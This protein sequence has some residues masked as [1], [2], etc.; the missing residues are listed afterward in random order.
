MAKK[1]KKNKVIRGKKM[2]FPHNAER[3][4]LR[5]LRLVLK[6]IRDNTV[7]LLIQRL[8]I[9]LTSAKQDYSN[10]S[11]SDALDRIIEEIDFLADP[12][13]VKANIGIRASGL[14]IAKYNS[15]QIRKTYDQGLGVN[16]F[17]QEP[18]LSTQLES[19]NEQGSALILSLSDDE[20]SSVKQVVL[21]S[22][23]EGQSLTNTIKNIQ[24]R[25]AISY[26]HAKLIARDQT[27]K[28]NGSLT[29]LR[30]ENLGVETYIWQTSSDDRVRASHKVL[31]GMEC[32]WIDSSVYRIPGEDKW[33]KKSSINAFEG[34]IGQDFQCRCV[35]IPVL[36]EE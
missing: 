25:F 6:N 13:R 28:L 1:K 36:N 33:R 10:R 21:R 35:S 32:S 14:E 16:I 7:Q 20:I 30:Q 23:S 34:Q 29:R 26:R 5:S 8:P 11:W 3:L 24:K 18:W 12:E 4:Y 2:I 27:A 22:V 15:K 19:F 31:D 17:S 9:I